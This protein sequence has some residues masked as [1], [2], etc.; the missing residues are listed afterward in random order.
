MSK[1]ERLTFVELGEILLRECGLDACRDGYGTTDVEW[2][3]RYGLEYGDIRPDG[4]LN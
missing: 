3:G 4:E 1:V 2:V